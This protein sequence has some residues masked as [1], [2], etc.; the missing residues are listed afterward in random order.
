MIEEKTNQKFK[1][2]PPI[3]VVLGHIDHGKT[4]LL[5]YIRKTHIA[6][7]ET[8][9]ITQ[10]I[11]AYEI[12][13]EGKKI[14]F[15]D[16]PG[17]EAFS[18]M[19]HRGA[20]VADIA[21]LVID[22]V[23]GVKTQTKEAIDHIK[24]IGL[25]AIVV[26][27]KIDKPGA[28]PIK[29]KQQLAELEVLVEG[30][31][32]DIPAV[33]I[34]AKTGQ[35]VNDLLD[36]ILLVAEMLDLKADYNAPAEGLI[37]ESFLDKKRGPTA[38][39]LIRNGIL[40]KGAIIATPSAIAKV[41]ILEDFQRKLIS[42]AYPSMPVVILGFEEVPKV[43]DPFKTFSDLENAQAYVVRKERKKKEILSEILEGDKKILNIILKADVLGSLEAI[44]EVFKGLPQD[45]VILRI[46]EA[47]VGDISE[48]DIKLASSGK[49]VIIGFRVGID[50]L[51]KRLLEREK[52]KIFKF[53]I[54]YDL[55]QKVREL[56][57]EILEP[58]IIRHDLGRA[59]VLVVFKGEKKGQVVG[60]RVV[61]GIIKKGAKIEIHREDK[62][63]DTGVILN[64]QKNKIDIEKAR[65][66]EEIGILYSGQKNPPIKKGDILVIFEEEKIEKKI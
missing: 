34:S 37:I 55:I 45:L 48:S 47:G 63:L 25:P 57:N 58:E 30:F 5:D 3:I 21:L 38:T 33:E 11:G 53:D 19:R 9:G 44:E 60:C 51:A 66:G 10:H 17:H 46:L 24:K 29:V 2:R 43:G 54:I 40:R 1:K 31:G 23:E 6:E 28:N 18:A 49:A 22:S 65:E 32:G 20:K 35:G 8:G 36:L 27:N 61:E 39:L 15:I 59:E 26:L 42:E 64:L 4:T 56:M 16:T 14:T 12:E 50:S 13:F 52:V 41:R 7:Q 62:I